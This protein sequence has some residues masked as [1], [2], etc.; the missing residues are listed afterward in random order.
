MGGLRLLL[1]TDDYISAPLRGIWPGWA[2]G[3]GRFTGLE[4]PKTYQIKYQKHYKVRF[5][6]LFLLIFSVFR[7]VFVT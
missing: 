3:G 2:V 4:P 6:D 5:V 1:R 7:G